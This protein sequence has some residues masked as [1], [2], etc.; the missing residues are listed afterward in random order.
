MGFLS[1]ITRWL[2]DPAAS[3]SLPAA[4]AAAVRI[5]AA[6][7]ARV[8]ASVAVD[9][10]APVGTS[11]RPD[12]ARR[13]R[14]SP[15]GRERPFVQGRDGF[16][17]FADDGRVIAGHA[18]GATRREMNAPASV[19]DSLVR[20]LAPADD[21]CTLAFHLPSGRVV[22]VSS[23]HH[24]AG[25]LPLAALGAGGLDVKRGGLL[26]LGVEARGA[27]ADTVRV[28]ALPQAY[29][30]PIFV[31]DIDDTLRATSVKD[32]LTGRT[33]PPIAGAKELLGAVAAL[34][35]PIVYLS[36]GSERLTA[37]NDK[38]L[39]QLP[40]GVLLARPHVGL[41]DLLPGNE[42]Q[43]QAQG[44]YKAGVLG[45]L[46]RTFPAAALFGLG[47]DKY[48]DAQ[49]YTRQGVT[50]F[51]RDVRPAHDNLPAD[52]EGALSATYAPDFVAN[53]QSALG[54]AIA[55]SA[56]FGGTPVPLD[57]AVELTRVLDK[58]SGARATPGNAVSLFIDGDAAKPQLLGT[59]DAASKSICY[60]TYNFLPHDEAATE[61]AAH[62]IAAKQRGVAVRVVV[63]SFGSREFLLH[64]NPTLRRL[65][66]AGITV[67]SYNRIDGL[68]DLRPDRD[69][70][71][72]VVVD[73][74]VALIGGM[75][76]GEDFLG[77]LGGPHGRHDVL[78][79]IVGPAV[80][81]ALAAFSDSW[82]AAGGA[83]FALGDVKA[84]KAPALPS[85][86][87]RVTSRALALVAPG[88]NLRLVTH[89]PGR[90]H[91]VRAAYL[92]LIDHAK[93]QI[94]IENT[95]P[96]ADDIA[97]SL[98]AAAQRGVTVRYIVG[99]HDGVLGAAAETRFG[100]LLAA[101]VQIYLYPD[102]VHTKAMAVD[103]SVCTFGS[104]NFD[105]VALVSNREIVA[106]VE[107]QAFTEQFDREVFTR[108]VVGDAQGHKTLRL[109][110]VD[111]SLLVRLRD[112]L[113][114]GL[115]PESLQ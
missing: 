99:T 64:P 73:A 1:G 105:E 17:A 67:C 21:R 100:R 78:G 113:L 101:G 90:D 32:L 96:L 102:R 41:A 60:E 30:G 68:D 12:E 86:P 48:G 27:T 49:A 20:I 44:A 50:A 63:D 98:V 39:A 62:L 4:E 83:P 94:D 81:D 70:R 9:A 16:V 45:E 91:N 89:A 40:P 97:D 34:G 108:D 53:V 31:C 88:A 8:D 18:A 80:A 95:Y 36:A 59:L 72:C 51:I 71:K 37:E 29:D 24:G 115:W 57:P 25:S 7:P 10:F 15:S 22:R 104:A 103:G 61:V 82:Q 13:V 56:A 55:R 114:N 75:N 46:V 87:S 69:H 42:H 85:I 93:K 107:D 11:G 58:L 66:E 92:A 23:D 76:T 54:Q 3:A 77:P 43:A 33:Q 109:T 19:F 65:Q 84:D 112:A 74:Q 28:L 110:H 79:R 5:T 47:D 52:F 111:K 6:A 14:A 106:V 26:D 2:I 38:F 35:V